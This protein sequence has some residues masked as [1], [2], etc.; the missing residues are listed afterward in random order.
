MVASSGSRGISKF[1]S[2]AAVVGLS[3][4]LLI[5]AVA[6]VD[7][8]FLAESAWGTVVLSAKTLLWPGLLLGRLGFQYTVFAVALAPLAIG[9]AAR[10]LM[11]RFSP[12]EGRRVAALAACSIVY[13]FIGWAYVFVLPIPRPVFSEYLLRGQPSQD[14]DFMIGF[15]TGYQRGMVETLSVP[16]LTGP[17]AEGLVRG[18]LQGVREWESLLPGVLEGWYGAGLRRQAEREREL[19]DS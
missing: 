8:G 16:N 14:R 12:R 2:A 17:F 19:S 18:Y 6:V 15:E 9:W 5:A 13:C 10:K 1:L 11:L 7:R 4:A 3:L